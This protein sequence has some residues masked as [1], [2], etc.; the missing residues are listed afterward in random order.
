MPSSANDFNAEEKAK[1]QISEI[2]AL[3]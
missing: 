3:S 1:K 2:K